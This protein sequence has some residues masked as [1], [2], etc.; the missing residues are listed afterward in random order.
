MYMSKSFFLSAALTGLL[1]TTISTAYSQVN[2]L[3]WSSSF[4]PAWAAG[5]TTGTATNIGGTTINCTVTLSFSGTGSF[6]APYPRVNANNSQAAD[7]QVQSSTDALEIDQDLANKT[8][9]S[10]V[11]YTFS[12]AVQNVQFGISDIDYPGPGTP[13]NYIDLVTI[14]ATGPNGSVVPVITKYNGASTVFSIA[15]NICTAN[16]GT[17]GAN[18]SSLV[19]GSPAQDG[20]AFVDFGT[21]A[22]TSITIQYGTVNNANV[23]N[24]PRLQAIS[25]GNL[26]FIPLSGLPIAFSQLEAQLKGKEVALQW[27]TLASKEE[28]LLY[29][30]RSRNGMQW[31][32]VPGISPFKI[33]ADTKYNTIDESPFPAVTFYRLKQVSITG[34]VLY[35]RIIR[36]NMAPSGNTYIRTYPNPFQSTFNL[37]VNWP[38]AERIAI[39]VYSMAGQIVHQ[40]TA[41][42][43]KGFQILTLPDFSKLPK[44]V[45]SLQVTGNTISQLSTINKQ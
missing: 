41:S 34:E 40:S 28:G 43:Q 4:S 45:Y 39:K 8:S 12:K 30:E 27:N 21:G 13:F 5:N 16:S 2:I 31:E 6:T 19:Q 7:F 15:S 36:V 14:T 11:V 26:T 44:G 37:E 1:L 9:F 17:G 10:R 20:T 33:I 38:E 32:A 3:D 25:I 23:R 24:N 42:V 18:V 29:V 35:S 22:I